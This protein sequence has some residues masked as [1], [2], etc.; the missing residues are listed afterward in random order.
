MVIG[1]KLRELRSKAGES[2]QQVA[3]AL[4]ITRAAVSLWETG[5]TL[6]TIENLKGVAAHFGVSVDA[7]LAE[8]EGR[9]A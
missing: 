7:L 8:D 4:G 5:Q 3:D 9:A 2:A 1:D 6:P